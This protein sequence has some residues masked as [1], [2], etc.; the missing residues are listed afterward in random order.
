[1]YADIIVDISA[2]NLDK[3]YQYLIPDRLK[4]RVAAGTPVI[5]P[6][7]KG[8]RTISGYVVDI[9]DKAKIAPERIKPIVSIKEKENSIDS[10]M[11]AL[12]WWIKE[13]FGSTMNDAL[14]TVIPVNKKVRENLARTIVPKEST[15]ELKARLGEA[16]RK[17]HVAKQRFLEELLSAGKLDY[18]LTTK[19][20]NISASV[21][22]KFEEEQVIR[23][24]SA[25]VYRNP[26]EEVDRNGYEKPILNEEQSKVSE[27]IISDIRNGESSDY[28]IHVITG[29]GKTE[30]YMSVIDEVLSRGKKVIMLIP[31]ISLTYQTVKRFYMRYGNRISI[32]NSRLSGG[33]RYD[34]YLRIK[35]GEADIC[36]GPRSALFAPF[37]DLGLII[38]DEEHE[39]SYISEKAPRYS[40]REVAFKRAGME[41]ASVILG[42]ATPSLEAYTMAKSGRIRLLSVLKRANNAELPD[43]HVVDMREEL[44]ARN[45]SIFSRELKD[46]ISDRLNRH[47]QIMLF[48]NRRGYTGTL[49]CRSCGHVIKCP[50]CDISLT[51]H[52]AENSVANA[53]RMTG[54]TAALNSRTGQAE[55]DDR[56]MDCH[57]CGDVEPVAKVCPECG[58]PYIGSFG[59]GT[60]KVEE[61][62]RS[63]F[64]DARVLRLDA[65]TTKNK[66]S[67]EE[68][69]SSFSNEEADILVGTQM[70]VKGHDFGKC[71]LVGILI[72]DMSLYSPDFRAGERTFQLLTQASGRAGRG[73]L[74]GDVVIQTYN[75]DHYC[76]ETASHAD[77]QGFYEDEIAYRKVM[78][79]P[80]A[81]C[82]LTVVLESKNEQLV[83][84]CSD[85]YTEMLKKCCREIKGHNRLV[86]PADAPLYKAN[87]YYRRVVTVKSDDYSMLVKLKDI[88]QEWAESGKSGASAE[89]LRLD[90][91]FD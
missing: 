79:Y 86:G 7:G 18:Y 87:D 57:Y 63:E 61:Y 43:V 11:V 1:M 54:R 36:I 8:N 88:T 16:V 45:R 76:I 50:H 42:S 90:Y 47:E 66:N 6:F 84:D 82:M 78:G 71:T 28:L 29:S 72:A 51:V 23:I 25:Q 56:T 27:T 81:R 5:I 34:Q 14:H 89:E 83:R 15:E 3:T 24:E 67:Y 32:I 64:P 91:I 58:S 48:L 35:R 52:Q 2:E 59:I 62:I 21:I 12:A 40:A 65:D 53:P 10:K 55:N 13:R 4:E 19:K 22:Q 77:Y 44:K 37:D 80:P 31:E 38:I 41:G 85:R 73:K 17:K 9:S 30:I 20:L 49:S 68:I 60:Q 39:G 26:F 33:E 46:L 74:K 70:I 75:P 69:L